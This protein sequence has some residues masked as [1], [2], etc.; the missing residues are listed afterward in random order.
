M[1]SLERLYGEVDNLSG[2]VHPAWQRTF[3]YMSSP[4]ALALAEA[5]ADRLAASGRR[6]VVVAETGA[7]P[8]A[9]LINKV[10]SIKGQR[11]SFLPVKFP[12]DPVC[13]IYPVL[14][15]F[16]NEKEKHL[17]AEPLSAI[18]QSMPSDFFQTGPADILHVLDSIS[19]EEP[20]TSQRAHFQQRIAALFQGTQVA[21]ALAQPFVYLD[22][23]IDSGTTFR[24]AIAF[25]HC[26]TEKPDLMTA[27]FYVRP[28][29]AKQHE[30]VLFVR[31]TADDRP[32]CFNGGAYPYEN[33]VDLIGHFYR[34]NSDE[35]VRTEVAE[36]AGGQ[37]DLCQGDSAGR[38]DGETSVTCSALEADA[39]IDRLA[40]AP[41]CPFQSRRDPLAFPRA[42]GKEIRQSR[43]SRA[44]RPLCS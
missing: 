33:R 40:K 41:L 16:L 25:F 38:A 20:D 18:C 34:I 5:I 11:L 12:R 7:S 44:L 4:Q 14:A 19:A 28:S 26:M 35:F 17:K 22:E 39:F 24:N 9:E 6:L 29:R 42:P 27:S 2:L 31:A 23:Y 15:S 32:A 13:N 10:A 21:T 37:F 8:L 36:I 1:R 30:R 3:S 43:S